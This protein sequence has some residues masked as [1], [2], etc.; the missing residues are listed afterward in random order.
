M[1]RLRDIGNVTPSEMVQAVMAMIGEG[2]VPDTLPDFDGEKPLDSRQRKIAERY[3]AQFDPVK[4]EKCIQ[5]QLEKYAPGMTLMEFIIDQRFGQV[6]A[7][8]GDA[9]KLNAVAVL[10]KLCVVLAACHPAI[11]N[12]LN[13]RAVSQSAAATG[14]PFGDETRRLKVMGA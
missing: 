5:A 8:K 3:I 11:S 10:E 2:E 13:C 1:A 9:A 12:R 14:S 6:F 7:E 4:L